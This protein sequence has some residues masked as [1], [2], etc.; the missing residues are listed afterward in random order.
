MQL[1]VL[2]VDAV[3]RMLGCAI[4]TVEERARTGDLP[5]LK[6]GDGGWVFP[7][8]ALAMRLQELALAEAAARRQP[9]R[10]V[11]VFKCTPVPKATKK[12]PP[13]LPTA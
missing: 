12:A 8:S 11:G 13:T 9:S 5:G 7:A 3:A 2:N 4:T 10:A 6:F 1:D